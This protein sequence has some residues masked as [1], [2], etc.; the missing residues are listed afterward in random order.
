MKGSRTSAHPSCDRPP[1]DADAVGLAA[2]A[3]L[4]V[5]PTRA[6]RLRQKKHIQ[7]PAT[8]SI[9]ISL[10]LF[11]PVN[12]TEFLFHLEG[13]RRAGSPSTTLPL[14]HPRLGGR[15]PPP[16][17]GLRWG[18]REAP[19]PAQEHPLA[20]S[21]SGSPRAPQETRNFWKSERN[22][23]L[24]ET[25]SSQEDTHKTRGTFPSLIFA[26]TSD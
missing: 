24:R 13:G 18:G 5:A 15:P 11:S 26:F 2:N 1:Q 12:W 8:C 20:A 10:R 16:G 6:Q 14:I 23:Q 17:A 25:G 3:P 22:R 4:K 7:T 19:A 9:V 21:A